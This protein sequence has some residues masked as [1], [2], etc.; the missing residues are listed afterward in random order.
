MVYT[1]GKLATLGICVFIMLLT[2][3]PFVSYNQSPDDEFVVTPN[4][5]IPVSVI[6]PVN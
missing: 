3:L 5:I 2:K 4:A 1:N 6:V